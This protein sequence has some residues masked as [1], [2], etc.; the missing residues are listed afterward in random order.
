MTNN[1]DCD[2]NDDDVNPNGIEVCN[3][4]DDDCDTQIDVNAT[5]APT[6]YAD[7]DG[8]T[9]GD[10]NNAV[11]NCTV[12]DGYVAN[13]SDSNDDPTTGSLFNPNIEEVCDGI[14]NDCNGII[15]NDTVS[16]LSLV[17]RS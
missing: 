10:E 17:S 9:F 7:A 5:N 16:G 15:D 14:D 8:D 1:L 13:S 12:P 11:T 2:D 4:E 6:W 3:G